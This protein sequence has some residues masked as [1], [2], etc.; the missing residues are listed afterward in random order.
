M[1]LPPIDMDVP[2]DQKYRAMRTQITQQVKGLGCAC[3]IAFKEREMRKWIAEKGNTRQA[4]VTVID[5]EDPGPCEE[6]IF[7]IF[8]AKHDDDCKWKGKGEMRLNPW[9]TE[10]K[11][12]ELKNE[13]TKKTNS[14]TEAQGCECGIDFGELGDIETE[15]KMN[16][17]KIHVL[18]YEEPDEENEGLE[19]SQ[20]AEEEGTVQVQAT[21]TGHDTQ[22]QALPRS[23]SFTGAK[24]ARQQGG[25]QPPPFQTPPSETE[26]DAA[27]RYVIK[28]MT[29]I[30]ARSDQMYRGYLD[31]VAEK[32][33]MMV[34]IRREVRK[35]IEELRKELREE[36]R[37][38]REQEWSGKRKQAPLPK[39][40]E[41]HS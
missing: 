17:G 31:R 2:E 34:E 28:T 27:M 10:K 3:Y 33:Q 18:V 35:G 9:T 15:M 29:G 16:G 36:M 23:K 20:W 7:T 32:D 25:Q 6:K 40:P 37:T 1:H 21:Q 39:K 41:V 11:G 22:S 14:E 26:I 5:N 13:V 8:F 4:W 19:N 12:R 30:A 24:K 38:P